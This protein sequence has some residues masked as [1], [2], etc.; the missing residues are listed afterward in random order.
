MIH[1]DEEYDYRYEAKG[2]VTIDEIF[3]AIQYGYYEKTKKFL[4]IY[5]VDHCIRKYETTKYILKDKK[6]KN[7][8]P[9]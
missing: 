3:E 5:W 9:P 7:L 6:E 2:L 4:P 8:L 1:P